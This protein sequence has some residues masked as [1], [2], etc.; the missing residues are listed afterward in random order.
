[1]VTA[2]ITTHNRSQLLKRS[3]DSV[4]NQTYKDIEL[5]VVSDGSTDGTDELMKRY[6]TNPQIKYISYKPSKGAN[7]ARN[8]GIKESSGDYLAFLDDDDEWMPSKIEEQM[9][10]LLSDDNIVLVYTGV[11]SIYDLGNKIIKYRFR[12]SHS[13][14]LS[15]KILI[16]NIIGSTSTPLFRKSILK[17][18]GLFDERLSAMQD[19]DLWVRI[20]QHGLIGVVKSEQ[21]LYYN[22]LSKNASDQISSNTSKYEKSNEYLA[23][24]YSIL[25]DKLTDKEKQHKKAIQLASLGQRSIR[26]NNSREA[27]HWLLASLKLEIK[28]NTLYLY[29]LSFGGYRIL[30]RLK[31][32]YSCL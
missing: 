2:I 23:K 11:L 21:V 5:I 15:K 14:D 25:F 27:R 24:K 22:Y 19:Y 28:L 13:G 9:S 7:Y 1:M 29:L 8:R 6:E 20:C 12:P 10:L 3:I 4:L 16:S 26:N 18:T 31:S 17:R 32:I 30:L